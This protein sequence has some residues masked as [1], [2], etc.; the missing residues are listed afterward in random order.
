M[1]YYELDIPR[2]CTALADWLACLI[3]IKFYLPPR[4]GG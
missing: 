1:A 4:F 3:Y 2:F